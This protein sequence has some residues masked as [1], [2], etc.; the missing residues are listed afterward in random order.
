MFLAFSDK[1]KDQLPRETADIPTQPLLGLPFESP[2]ATSVFDPYVAAKK[3][4]HGNMLFTYS[5][6][7][8]RNP[9]S[10]SATSRPS[11][12][13]ALFAMT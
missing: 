13:L 2:F 5:D 4:L 8:M 7:F 1:S 6:V 3:R 9:E 11:Q 10:G 12:V